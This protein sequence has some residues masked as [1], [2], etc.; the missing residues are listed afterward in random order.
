MALLV[1]DVVSSSTVELLQHLHESLDA[2]FTPLYQARAALNPSSPVF[3]LEHDLS[4]DDLELLI[5]TVRSAIQ[6]GLGARH[7][8]WWLPFVVYAAEQGYDYVGDEYW[9]SFEQSTPGWRSDQRH[10]IKAWF[11]LFAA[12]YGGA[13]P[14]GA[15]ASNFTIIAWPITHG[16]LPTYLQRQLAQLLFEFS[17]ALTSD[18][19]DDPAALGLRLVRRA[20]AYTERFRI[21][22]EN[23]TLVGQVAAALLSGEDEPT[24]YLLRSTLSRIVEGVSAEQQARHWLKSA[25]QSASRARGFQRDRKSTRLNSSHWE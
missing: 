23:T 24:P 13:V 21:F 16:V 4:P 19:L 18:L 8:A 11:Q 25:Q 15:F 3:A 10:W 1:V 7:R 9:R 12:E 14:T 5:S 6:A 20:P 22:C 2:H 17:G